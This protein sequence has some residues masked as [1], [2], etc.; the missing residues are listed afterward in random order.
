MD[1]KRWV[2]KGIRTTFIWTDVLTKISIT[3]R[4]DLVPAVNTDLARLSTDF[5]YFA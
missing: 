5:V 3:D 4:T 1:C 2:S